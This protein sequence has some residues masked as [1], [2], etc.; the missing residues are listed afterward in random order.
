MVVDRQPVEGPIVVVTSNPSSR[1][2]SSQPAAANG[3]RASEMISIQDERG[4]NHQTLNSLEER[5]QQDTQDLGPLSVPI[6]KKFSE[7]EP[8]RKRGSCWAKDFLKH[9]AEGLYYTKL[10]TRRET[11]GAR[12]VEE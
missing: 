4:M 9:Y 5:R 10:S 12:K 6:T 8:H 3:S 2:R 1:L 7:L 11:F